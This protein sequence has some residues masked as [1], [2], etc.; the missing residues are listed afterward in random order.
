MVTRTPMSKEQQAKFNEDMDKAGKELKFDE[1]ISEQE[2][3][4]EI[5]D[6]PADTGGLPEVD[7][8]DDQ[9]ADEAEKQRQSN[10]Q[11]LIEEYVSAVESEAEKAETDEIAANLKELGMIVE[12]QNGA[13]I[14]KSA[15]PAGEGGGTDPEEES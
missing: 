14:W 12:V 5:I 9:E 13:V 7:E 2:D 8:I 1:E 15:G 10:I 11:V 4:S 3:G 6:P